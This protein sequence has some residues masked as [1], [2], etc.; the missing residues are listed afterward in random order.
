MG[1]FEKDINNLEY[2]R[3]ITIKRSYSIKAKKPIIFIDRMKFLIAFLL[4]KKSP[5]IAKKPLI[6][7]SFSVWNNL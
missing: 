1:E 4:N 2:D 3:Y 6:N 7:N 5:Q